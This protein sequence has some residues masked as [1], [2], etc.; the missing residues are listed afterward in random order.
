[1]PPWEDDPTIPDDEILWRRVPP[2]EVKYDTA[3]R[4][5]PKSSNFKQGT[6]PLSV[7]IASLSTEELTLQNYEGFLI[8]AFT[9]GQ[10]RSLGCKI[11]RQPLPDNPSHALVVG[12]HKSDANGNLTGRFTQGQANKLAQ[13]AT[14]ISKE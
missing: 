1:M 12:S 10:A 2:S 8:A 4:P 5:F 9:A 3:G 14:L 7:N 13:L 11:V 6:P